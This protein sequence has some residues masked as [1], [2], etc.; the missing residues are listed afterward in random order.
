MRLDEETYKRAKELGFRWAPKQELFVAPSWSPQRE[1]FCIE[2]AGEIGPEQTTVIERAQAKA[3]RLDILAAK[4][5]QDSDVFYNAA[6]SISQRF[7]AGQ[8]ILIGHHSERKARRDQ[9]KMHN[10]M[11]K[12]VR[13]QKAVS[14]WQYRADGVEHHANRKSCPAVRARRIKKL[15]ADLRS[16]QR[17]INHHNV[18]L[19]V[20]LSI[21]TEAGMSDFD[22]KVS[23]YAGASNTIGSYA[24][25]YQNKSL[26]RQLEDGSISSIEAVEKCIQF[27][28]YRL[29]D[30]Y[31]FRWISH[32]LNRLAFE[33][34]ELGPVARYE[35]DL[36]PVILQA[37]ARTHGADKPKAKKSDK[38]F[39]LSCPLDLPMHI[40]EG[41]ALDLSEDEWRDLMESSGYEVP[42]PKPKAAPILNFKAKSI[43]CFSY[44]NVNEYHQI[45]MTKAEYG[46]IDKDY[47]GTRLSECKTFRFKTCTSRAAGRSGLGLVAV[48][49]T[50][51][52]VHDTPDSPSI[53]LAEGDSGDA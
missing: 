4:R 9:E 18:C 23:Y 38:G 2:L 50:D 39:S 24:P 30:P 36:T 45:E 51:S 22:K 53:T 31:T 26:W 40:G 7:E 43:R 6:H 12:A 49:L 35:G 10:A 17:R 29:Q 28:E 13:A 19:R 33:R 16:F 5:A 42:A 32:T 20:W 14:Y 52:K 15:L 48:F 21:K 3:E 8:P 44:G 46:A 27:H 1:D 37:F 41:R 34:S 25:Y 47:R 11:R